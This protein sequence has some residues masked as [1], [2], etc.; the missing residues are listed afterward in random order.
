VRVTMEWYSLTK[1]VEKIICYHGSN[2]KNELHLLFK[3]DECMTT[4][5]RTITMNGRIPAN[6]TIKCEY[7]CEFEKKN[8]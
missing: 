6:T 3:R 2:M 1:Q 4:V 5:E 8:E 7:N